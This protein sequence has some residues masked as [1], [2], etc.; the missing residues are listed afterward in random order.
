MHRRLRRRAR[1]RER[2]TEDLLSRLRRPARRPRSRPRRATRSSPTR[3]RTAGSDTSQLLATTIRN[4][5][6]LAS[7]TPRE[8][9]R[10]P[11]SAVR[12]GA[13]GGVRPGCRSSRARGGRERARR[14]SPHDHAGAQATAR[15]GPRPYAR[16]NGRSRRPAP[17]GLL[18]GRRTTPKRSARRAPQRRRRRLQ[19]D[20]RAQR[21]DQQRA[22][23][24]AVEHRPRAGARGRP[25]T[26][27]RRTATSRT[28]P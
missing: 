22:D 28:P 25:G 3:S 6:P 17:D 1:Q 23:P 18:R 5:A 8:R 21:I 19:P 24:R 11:G 13:T 27:T 14:T 10:T 12:P 15:R 4:P 9:H 16:G 20:Q 2:R 7:S 26:P